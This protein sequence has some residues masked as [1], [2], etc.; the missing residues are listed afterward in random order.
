MALKQ[1]DIII[2]PKLKLGDTIGIAAPASPFDQKKFD[3]GIAVLKT[4]GFHVHIPANLFEKVNYLAGSDQHRANTLNRLFE[5]KTINGII[6][7]RGGYG[8]IRILPLL[9]YDMIR[10][11]PKVFCGF[12]DIS[13]LL[14]V[15]LEQ[16]G[17]AVFHGPVVTTLHDSTDLSKTGLLETLTSDEHPDL[18]LDHGLTIQS[19]TA[20][21]MITGGNLTTVCHLVGTLF[22]PDFRNRILLLED[23]GE[24]VYRID[25]MLTHLKLAGCL[26]GLAGLIVGSFEDCGPSDEVYNLFKTFFK[27]QPIPILGGFEAGHGKDNRTIPFG[28]EAELDA[29]RHQLTFFRQLG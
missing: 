12:S 4:M 25:R 14:S 26:E 24:A 20:K 13:A 28:I 9:D 29:D 8:S 23:R 2:P 6:C 19:G 11:N 15:L 21:G 18:K 16:S 3:A 22:E 10:N 17:L 7:A 5:D 1:T 27:D